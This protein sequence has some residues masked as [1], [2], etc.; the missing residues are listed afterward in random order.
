MTFTQW[1][2]K[3]YRPYP[4]GKMELEEIAKQV[5]KAAQENKK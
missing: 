4:V 1:W 5:W 2:A 3:W